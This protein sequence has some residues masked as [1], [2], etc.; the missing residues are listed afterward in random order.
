MEK[1]DGKQ[2]NSLKKGNIHKQNRKDNEGSYGISHDPS[3]LHHT[4]RKHIEK[5]KEG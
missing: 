3:L 2:A 4:Q 1:S 5:K